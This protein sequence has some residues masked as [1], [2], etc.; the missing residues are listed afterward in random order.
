MH[1]SSSKRFE[2]LGIPGST[3]ADILEAA[4]RLVELHLTYLREHETK[5]DLFDVRD[6]PAS[7]DSL[8]NAF[9]L[10]LATENRTHMRTLLLK[11]GM[12]L[13]QFQ[14]NIG[15]PMIVKSQDGHKPNQVRRSDIDAAVARRFNKALVQLGEERARLG[16]VF[17]D[18]MRIAGDKPLH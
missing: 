10:T 11:A 13:A 18:A 6:L 1:Q 2:N 4:H 12:T 15:R 14:E 9:R 7:K 17:Q 8:V 16:R 3:D 5:N